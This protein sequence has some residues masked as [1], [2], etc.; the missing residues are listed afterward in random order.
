MDELK[1]ISYITAYNDP[2]SMDANNSRLQKK[3]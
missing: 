3:L 1:K 2:P